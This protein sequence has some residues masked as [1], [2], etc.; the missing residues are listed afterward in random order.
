MLR[1]GFM[2]KDWA[3]IRGQIIRLFVGGVKSFAGKVPVG[4]TGGANVPPLLSMEIPEALQRI[5][6]SNTK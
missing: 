4:N 1:F 5:L 2:I 3:E 6:D